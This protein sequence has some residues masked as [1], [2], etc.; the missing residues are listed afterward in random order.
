[1]SSTLSKVV[2]FGATGKTGLCS[3]E[4]ALKRGAQVTAL[5]RDASRLPSELA[6]KITVI[7][8]DSTVKDDVDKAIS[9]QDGV[10]VALGTGHDLSY[11]TVMSSSMKL[12]LDSMLEQGVKN[13][14]VCLSSFLFWEPERVP[15]LFAEVNA[16]HRRM[17]DILQSPIYTELNW[18]A[19]HPPHIADEPSSNDQFKVVHGSCPGRQIPKWDLGQFM[20]DCLTQSEHYH[21][22]CGLAH[23]CA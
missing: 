5:V 8:G 7:Q 13:I 6:P 14:S 18:V 15:A 16:D 21:Q 11:T 2:V 19:V 22:H 23:P 17:Q 10:I 1:M 12:I 3:I 9:G 4:R 20:F